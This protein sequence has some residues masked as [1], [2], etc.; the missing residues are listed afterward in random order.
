MQYL[1]DTDWAIDY[2]HDRANVVRRLE[3]LAPAG[4]GL[5]IISLA[6]LYEGVF[7]S[8]DP[9]ASERVLWNFLHR[10][11]VVPV[12]DDICRTF[13]AE[14]RRLRAAGTLISDFDLM[15]GATAMHHGLTLLTNNRRHFDRLDGL[16]II[17][18]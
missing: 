4:L 3:E 9:E 12:D 1:V 18:I 2:L 8:Y 7:G 14:R 5:S 16:P 6:K 15:I 11:Q 10:I 13:A 17:S